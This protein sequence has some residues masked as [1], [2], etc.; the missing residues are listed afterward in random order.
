MKNLFPPIALLVLGAL[1]IGS[2]GP[3]PGLDRNAPGLPPSNMQAPQ[4]PQPGGPPPQGPQP[5]GPQPNQP[6][7]QPNGNPGNPNP[8]ITPIKALKIY[9]D[10]AIA[11][12]FASANKIMATISNQGDSVWSSPIKLMCVGNWSG[13]NASSTVNL[14]LN[15]AA[16]TST[17]V[18]SGLSRPSSTKNP[19]IDCY[20]IQFSDSDSSNDQLSKT[21]S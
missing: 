2:C 7:P 19:S 14:N 3:I 16:G 15:L 20:F 5:Q 4:G 18:D 1:L 10:L 11:N 21:L 17:D 9:P 8:A 12:I 13:G 6:G